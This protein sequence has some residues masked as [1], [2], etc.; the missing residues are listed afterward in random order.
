MSGE[1]PKV[2]YPISVPVKVMGANVDG[3]ADAIA[4]VAREFDPAFDAAAMEMR[5]SSGG[6]WMSLTITVTAT[7]R[8]HLE[9][10]NRALLAHP[11]VKL[12]I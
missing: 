11:M 12:V 4:E 8:E 9:A 3:F 5:A 7:S 1:G 2:D 6:N 10:L